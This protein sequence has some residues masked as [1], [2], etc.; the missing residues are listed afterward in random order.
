MIRWLCC[1]TNKP[2]QVVQLCLTGNQRSDGG[3]EYAGRYEEFREK[4][5]HVNRSLREN[6]SQ[7][8]DKQ[9]FA[10][11]DLEAFQRCEIDEARIEEAK[12]PSVARASAAA[13]AEIPASVTATQSPVP[14][15]AGT[16]QPSVIGEERPPVPTP[17]TLDDLRR[18][19][20]REPKRRSAAASSAAGEA[21]QMSLF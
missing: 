8:D 5:R 6:G 13:P 20:G 17:I 11:L 12:E 21:T 4:L 10:A 19:L 18:Q 9:D 3:W 7:V 2:H 15:D 16:P 14:A 1:E